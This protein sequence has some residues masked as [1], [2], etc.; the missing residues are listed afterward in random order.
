MSAKSS[1]ISIPC[2][3]TIDMDNKVVV[4]LDHACHDRKIAKLLYACGLPD[5]SVYSLFLM[6]SILSSPVPHCVLCC[7]VYSA[8]VHVCTLKMI[9]RLIYVCMYIYIYTYIYI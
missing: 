4:T 3:D 7:T 2:L 5:L 9:D 8:T 1:I 6:T